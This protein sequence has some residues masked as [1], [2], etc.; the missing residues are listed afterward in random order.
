MHTLKGLVLD[1]RVR[2]RAVSLDEV[3]A[4]V[5][6]LLPY[7][8]RAGQRLAW[9]PL[10]RGRPFLVDDPEFD[11]ARQLDERRLTAP[12]DGAALD[13]VLY[14]FANRR[15]DMNRPLW[16]ATLVHGWRGGRQAIAVALHHALADEMAAITTFTEF[17]SDTAGE[18]A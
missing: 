17:T 11:I 5:R 15:L 8:P 10:Y 4:A 3:A 2:G 13:G 1:P 14:E 6:R 12:G 9:A 18:V 16:T 7:W